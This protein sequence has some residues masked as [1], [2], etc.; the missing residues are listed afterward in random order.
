MN[1]LPT[2]E[3][4]RCVPFFDM[5]LLIGG[6][7]YD[8][9]ERLFGLSLPRFILGA[10]SLK[11]GYSA[12]KSMLSGDKTEGESGGEKFPVT[13]S[14]ME[15]FTAPQTLVPLTTQKTQG[16][17]LIRPTAVLD[18][19]R[20]LISVESFRVSVVPQN[21]PLSYK[22]A[23]L[24]L[25]LH[26]R[27]RLHEVAELVR[28]DNYGTNE[29]LIEYGWSHPDTSGNNAFGDIINSMRVKEKYGVFNSRFSFKPNGS[30]SI[31][32]QLYL[33]GPQAVSYTHLTLPTTPN[34]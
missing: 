32:L 29:I 16:D 24:S 34:M 22:S 3:L 25:L 1:S 15:I 5:R 20:P 31:S 17:T 30:V 13:T 9:D 2:H 28:P 7:P 23:E 6:A 12:T 26:D 8:G 10:Q 33:K 4:S 19:F 21:G 11:E 14:G 27:S 18:K